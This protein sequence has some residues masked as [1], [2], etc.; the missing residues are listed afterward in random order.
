MA[1]LP[2]AARL[3]AVIA[4]ALLGAT[5]VALRLPY[6]NGPPYATWFQREVPAERWHP[7]MAPFMLAVLGA[8]LWHRRRGA[9]R[10]PLLLMMLAVAC[11]KVASIAVVPDPPDV[12]YIAH[13]VA[14]PDTTSYHTDAMALRH[15]PHL[16]AIYPQVL[17]FTN[18]HTK[19]KPPGPVLYYVAM[20]GLFGEGRAAALAGGIGLAVLAA[21]ALP[22]AWWLARRMGASRSAATHAAALLA[23][24]PGFFHSYPAFDPF[25]I[26]PACALIGT[27]VT[28]V[29][30]G[31]VRWAGGAGVVFFAMTFVTYNTLVLGVF[32]LAAPFALSRGS[33]G[34]TARRSAALAP[35]GVATAAAL[36]GLL[37]LPTAYDPIA[38]FASALRNQ[39]DLL[40]RYAYH[41]PYPTTAMFDLVDFAFGA[42]WVGALLAAM[43]IASARGRRARVA[44]LV[45]AQL[46]IVAASALL[47]A[48]TARAWNFLYPLLL[49]PAGTELARWTR[50]SALAAAAALAGV[51]LVIGQNI[52]MIFAP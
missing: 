4:A 39:A 15:Q 27:W 44:W 38:T 52:Q 50:W 40:E 12:R 13:L 10:G 32:A 19:S 23:L 6:S 5:A 2:A 16:L 21:L 22:A 20:A 31:S 48:E 43:G 34:R 29:R 14:H 35:V 18:L 24:A 41:R 45:V 46:V 36:Y 42:G 8:L 17:P 37:W 49:L 11:G 33:A 26:V 30:R 1:R 25:Y 7:A 47:A 28:A 51:T 3:A 9:A